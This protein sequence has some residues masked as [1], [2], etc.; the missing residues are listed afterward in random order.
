MKAKLRQGYSEDEILSI[1]YQLIVG[2]KILKKYGIVHLDI[3]PDNIL[4]QNG[5]YKY[6]DFG[7]AAIQAASKSVR[8]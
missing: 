6:A 1:I 3:K 8:R 2:Y 4:I 7:L 5:V